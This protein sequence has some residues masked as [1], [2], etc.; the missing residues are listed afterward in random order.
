MRERNVEAFPT[1]TVC[2]SLER[3]SLLV[4]LVRRRLKSSL[5]VLSVLPDGRR[6]PPGGCKKQFYLLDDTCDNNSDAAFIV[7]LSLDIG[8]TRSPLVDASC[9]TKRLRTPKKK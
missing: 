1:N 7:P 8:R 5:S 3:L 6:L 9:N 2:V 4:G